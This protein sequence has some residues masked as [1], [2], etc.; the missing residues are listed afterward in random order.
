MVVQKKGN[1]FS[2]SAPVLCHQ[3]NCMGSMG[4]GI[5]KQVKRL[6][7]GVYAEYRSLCRAHRGRELMGFAQILPADGCEGRYIANCF[8]QYKT[9][10]IKQST[11]YDALRSS[12][13]SVRAWTAEKGIHAAALP[14]KIGCGYGGGDWET[15]FGIISDVFSGPDITVE[16]WEL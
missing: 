15:V 7:P 4:A 10:L 2:S 16:I 6:Y 1:L 12:L 13:E 9:S 14:Y 11:E 5:A 8:G 3:V